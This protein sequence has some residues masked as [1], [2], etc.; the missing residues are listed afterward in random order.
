MSKY[1]ERFKI[2]Q[3]KQSTQIRK[4]TENK[5]RAV[6]R[7]NAFD[8]TRQMSHEEQVPVKTKL[9]LRIERLKLFQEAK[10]KKIQAENANKK[11][12]WKNPKA[13]YSTFGNVGNEKN[14]ES[15]SHIKSCRSNQPSSHQQPKSC[16][17]SSK[18]IPE[19]NSKKTVTN[20]QPNKTVK[21]PEIVVNHV[22]TPCTPSTSNYQLIPGHHEFRR[23]FSQKQVDK[24]LR[25][26]LPLT[27][28]NIVTRAKK[29]KGVDELLDITYN[30]FS[31]IEN[32]RNISL[33]ST[34]SLATA[35]GT[36][37]GLFV[38]TPMKMPPKLGKLY[39]IF[40]KQ[41]VKKRKFVLEQL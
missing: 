4:I 16:V 35:T 12:G 31:N 19:K 5:N 39:S 11:P 18:T 27:P 23:P 21:T 2:P 29:R 25:Q 36:E 33:T 17:K 3:L 14:N 10:N 24:I 7:Q 15:A 40:K 20:K 32:D 13:R 34:P 41:K 28:T 6:G 8:E 26:T 37:A 1:S 38:V 22:S 9:E 30:T